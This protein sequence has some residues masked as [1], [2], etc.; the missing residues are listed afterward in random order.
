MKFSARDY[1]W[2]I[3]ASLAVAVFCLIYPIYVIRPFRPQGPRELMLA[4][5]VVRCRP[6]VT[7]ACLW[8]LFAAVRYWQQQSRW[9]PRIGVSLSAL[10][11]LAATL[12]SRVNVYELMFHPMG[13]PAF[14]AAADSKLNQ[15][16]MVVAVRVHNV[17]RAYPI[18]GMSYHHI[19]NDAL[20]GVAIAATY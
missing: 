5:F 10:A 18:R 9:W 19:V 1:A 14:E 15:D 7:F 16:E 2:T 12:L 13:A 4:L 8:S 3:L 6:W 11:V 17:A 20:D